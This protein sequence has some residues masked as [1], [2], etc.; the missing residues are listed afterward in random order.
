M[1]VVSFVGQ[2]VT[3]YCTNKYIKVDLALILIKR[4]TTI[5]LHHNN[6]NSNRKDP[7]KQT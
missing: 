3:I 7:M 2:Y 5:R 1:I 6:N 4:G